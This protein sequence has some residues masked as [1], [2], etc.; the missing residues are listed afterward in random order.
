MRV[1]PPEPGDAAAVF[2]LIVARDVADLGHAD[3]TLGDVEADWASPGV[4][5]AHDA[6]LV[7]EGDAL[8]GHALLDER[9]TAMVTVPPA[10]EGCGVGTRLREAAVAR[11]STRGEAVVHQYV[12]AA[13]A[14]ARTH[15]RRSG[16]RLEYRYLRMRID[17]AQA[18]D[19]PPDVPVRAYVRGADDRPVHELVEAAMADVSGSLP[20]SLDAWRA[21]KLDKAGWDP[22]CGSS[23]RTPRGSRASRRRGVGHALLLHALATLRAAGLTVGEL[24]VQSDNAGAARLYES[25]GMHPAWTSE[26][27]DKALAP[28]DGK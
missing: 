22:R 24:F 27:W 19:P 20:L 26:R 6:W 16:Y 21:V 25:V 12:P 5:L 3:Y 14:A 18:P 15:L 28:G 8:L 4:D 11:A 1:R 17:L 2:E 13:N 9:G 7:E 10:A 23:T